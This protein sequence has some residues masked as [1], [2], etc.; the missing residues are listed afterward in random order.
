MFYNWSGLGAL[1]G[2][3]YASRNNS[4]TWGSIGCTNSTENAAEDSYLG[5]VSSDPDSIEG[6]FSSSTHPLFNV[7]TTSITANTCNATNA[8][9]S[10]GP[11]TNFY[12][13]L[14][15]DGSSNI[16]YTTIIDENTAGFNGVTSDFQL[17]VG[18]NG[19][20]TSPASTTYYFYI[21][22]S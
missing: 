21:E 17:L 5:K 18:E 2:E 16:V 6:T 9:D 15:A 3:V 20:E 22:L 13:V 11:G 8:Y 19:N 1:A 14:L 10:G 12:Q 7:G 4:V